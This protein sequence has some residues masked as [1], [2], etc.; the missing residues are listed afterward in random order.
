MFPNFLKIHVI[1]FTYHLERGFMKKIT[2]ENELVSSLHTS[3][4][5]IYP[6]RVI[7]FSSVFISHAVIPEIGYLPND[8]NENINSVAKLLSNF[9]TQ[10]AS[11]V[12]LFSLS[13]GL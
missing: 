6:L 1:N 4:S 9:Y 5:F 3:D 2:R 12:A 11:G 8:P 10:G 13:L 7:A